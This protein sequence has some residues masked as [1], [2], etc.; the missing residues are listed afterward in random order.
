MERGGP[1][2]NPGGSSIVSDLCE[3]DWGMMSLVSGWLVNRGNVIRFIEN[4]KNQF[5]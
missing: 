3:V 5:N 4:T 2:S 1:G